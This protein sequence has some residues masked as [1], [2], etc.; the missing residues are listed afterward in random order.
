MG[1][2]ADT[3]LAHQGKVIGII[4]QFLQDR[5]VAHPNLTKTVIVESMSERKNKMVELGECLYCF[6]WRT[7]HF[8]RDC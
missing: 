3:V 6:A 5:E 4:P 7:R 8:R 2:V 1:V